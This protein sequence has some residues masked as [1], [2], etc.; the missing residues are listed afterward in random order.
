MGTPTM[1]WTFLYAFVLLM[2]TLDLGAICK[3]FNHN[4]A[5]I[6]PEAICFHSE[7]KNPNF[8]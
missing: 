1:F 4:H 5:T 6:E 7:Y 8:I 3:M 2:L